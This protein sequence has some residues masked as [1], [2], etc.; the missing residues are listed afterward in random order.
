MTITKNHESENQLN[1]NSEK[2][3]QGSDVSIFR[4]YIS[5]YAGRRFFL[6][7][8]PGNHGDKLIEM[9]AE[10]VLRSANVLNVD[11]AEDAEIILINGGGSFNT[12]WSGALDAAIEYREKYSDTKIVVGPQSYSFDESIR[13]KLMRLVK[14]GPN[15]LTLFARENNSFE[16]LQSEIS[17]LPCTAS[18][19]LSQDLAFELMDSEVLYEMRNRCNPQH[20]LV[21]FR[22]DI[23]SPFSGLRKVAGVQRHLEWNRHPRIAVLLT[24][25]VRRLLE[26]ANRSIG[27]KIAIDQLGLE[28][29]K[30]PIRFIDASTKRTF[31]DFLRIVELSKL[32]ITDRLHVAIYAHLLG[33]PLTVVVGDQ[34]HKVESVY[35]LSMAGT[36]SK[37][38]MVDVR[39]ISIP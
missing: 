11:R 15:N 29:K 38:R 1:W 18:V 10:L 9:G 26:F 7:R 20:V 32:V 25:C 33:I 5:N 23:E 8:L 24:K 12:Y 22:S 36:A 34:F 30:L 27:S 39:G 17:K 35:R 21:S 2:L 28:V 6:H 4:D 31:D 14:L 37:T 16:I 19:F 3:V 13:S